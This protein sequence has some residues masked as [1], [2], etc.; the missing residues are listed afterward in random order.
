MDRPEI[1]MHTSLSITENKKNP[2][3]HIRSLSFFPYSG[4]CL[5]VRDPGELPGDALNPD[6]HN[7]RYPDHGFMAFKTLIPST[8]FAIPV[9]SNLLAEKFLF[10]RKPGI[11]TY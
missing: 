11:C 3:R 1:F 8:L 6:D 5:G 2:G 9:A 10:L 4:K 7:H